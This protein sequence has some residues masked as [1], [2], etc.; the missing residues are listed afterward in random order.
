MSFEGKRSGFGAWIDKQDWLDRPAE[1]VQGWVL[2][3]YE[4]MGGAGSTLKSLAHG[5]KPLGHPLHPALVSMP[6]GAFAVMVLADWITVFTRAIPSEVG[7]FALIIGIIGM[8]GAAVTGY[9]DYTGTIGR[10]RRYATVHGATMTTLLV[11]MIV[12]LVLR[13]G[14][15]ASLFFVGVLLSTVAYLVMLWGAY[16]GGDLSFGFGTMV[17]HN[18]FVEGV[19]D[20]T[21]VGTTKKFAE[22]KP[23]RVE[24]GDMAVLIV[25]LGGG[26]NAI[27]ATCSHAGGPLDE[28]ELV[29][30]VVTCPWH[31]SRF[32]VADGRVEGGP[33]T[34]DQPAYQVRERDGKVEVKL[35]FPL[36]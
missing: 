17:N 19:T 4:V 6:I 14:H 11:A 35:P 3:L 29:D 13:Y 7:P 24:A 16:V 25:R 9:T 27:G 36:H 2:K 33:A 34:F 28:G 12:S 18:A 32:C 8:L 10:E 15:G 30:D 23:V 21:E 5:T 22:R 31:G 26:L 20:W 1:V